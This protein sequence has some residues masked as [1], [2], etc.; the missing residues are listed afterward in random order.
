MM[1]DI[2]SKLEHGEP[3]DPQRAAQEA[4]RPKLAKRFYKQVSVSQEVRDGDGQ[5]D[6][7]VDADKALDEALR[8][9]R[10]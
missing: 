10:E 5:P 9:V 7:K 8:L 6:V 1:R 2:L 4:M 3:V